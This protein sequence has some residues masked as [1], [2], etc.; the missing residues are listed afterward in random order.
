MNKFNGIFAV[1]GWP[2]PSKWPRK[3]VKPSTSIM[4]EN[5]LWMFLVISFNGS[6]ASRIDFC[7]LSAA[8]LFNCLST[9]SRAESNA[10]P[11]PSCRMPTTDSS[12]GASTSQNWHLCLFVLISAGMPLRVSF[13]NVSVWADRYTASLIPFVWSTEALMPVKNAALTPKLCSRERNVSSKGSIP[14]NLSDS[15]PFMVVLTNVAPEHATLSRPST[16]PSKP[17]YA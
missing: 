7:N 1:S 15:L 6:A 11:T 5:V 13:N 10:E 8:S 12:S 2:S 9:S 16:M 3:S 14:M 17:E 4:P